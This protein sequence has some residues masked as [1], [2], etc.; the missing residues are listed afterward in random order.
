MTVVAFYVSISIVY[1]GIFIEQT[2][3]ANKEAIRSRMVTKGNARATIVFGAL[4]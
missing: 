2:L 4:S 3:G 1:L